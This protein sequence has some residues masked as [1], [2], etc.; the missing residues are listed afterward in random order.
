MRRKG[1]QRTFGC[2]RETGCRGLAIEDLLDRGWGM[3]FKTAFKNGTKE[4]KDINY[5]ATFLLTDTTA[6]NQLQTARGDLFRKVYDDYSGSSYLTALMGAEAIGGNKG[7]QLREK[8]R[9]A[10]RYKCRYNDL[11][12][13]PAQ[14]RLYVKEECLDLLKKGYQNPNLTWLLKPEEGSQGSGITFHQDVDEIRNKRQEFFPCRDQLEIPARQRFLVQEYIEKP[15]LLKGTKFDLRVYMLV[16]R[17]DPW[18]VF[19]H[20]GYLRRSLWKYSA[21][22]KDRKV[23]LTNTHFQSRKVGFKLSEHIWSFKTFQDYLSEKGRTSKHYVET[24]LNPYI[25]EVALYVFMSAKKKLKPRAGSFQIIGLDFMI[26]EN[27]A[28]HFI[29]ANG[30]PGYTWSINFDSR[31]MVEEQFDLVQEISEGKLLNQFV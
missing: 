19:Y 29:E 4:F 31:G 23:Y 9:M 26:D 18:F 21:L 8:M 6:L 13:Q 20:E 28:V 3:R 1:G 11:G 10:K 5:H 25:K 24:I 12:I 22:S 7:K 2:L 14:Y 15:L 30:Y 16:A 27:Y 17:S